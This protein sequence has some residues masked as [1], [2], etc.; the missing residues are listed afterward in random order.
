MKYQQMEAMARGLSTEELNDSL[1]GIVADQRFAAVLRLIL[2]QKEMAADGAS[3]LKFAEL[4]GMLAH[5]AG[6]RYGMIE[7]EGRIKAICEPPRKR[8][9]R[10]E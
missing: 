6:V 1:K 2:D 5:A 10:A 3:Q 8:G 7:L 9:D 4:H